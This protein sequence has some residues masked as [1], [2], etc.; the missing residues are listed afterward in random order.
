MLIYRRYH[1]EY[2]KEAWVLHEDVPV[3]VFC[4]ALIQPGKPWS[5]HLCVIIRIGYNKILFCQIKL[6]KKPK[7]PVRYY[8]NMMKKIS[9]CHIKLF[10]I[11]KPPVCCYSKL[12]KE[13]LV[14]NK[15]NLVF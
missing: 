13:N 2:H 10:K 8:S 9:L 6:F 3:E 11:S 14:S 4:P 1:L 15:M 5:H 7:P 12:I